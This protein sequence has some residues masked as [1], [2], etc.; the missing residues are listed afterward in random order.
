VIIKEVK[1][2]DSQDILNWRNNK[3]SIFFSKKK[4]RI[5]LNKHKI[6][7]SRNLLSP[8]I[9]FYMGYLKKKKVGVVRFNI[10]RKNKYAIVSI[11]LN[12]KMRN[13]SLSKTLLRLAIKKFLKF[14]K[15]KFFAEI[16]KNNHRSINCFI[17]NDFFYIKTKNNFNFYKRN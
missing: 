12:P 3:T 10:K 4:K 16:E 2:E 5:S 15:I 11:N 6:W 1:K 8:S 7:F 17:K 14:K 13:K 9:K